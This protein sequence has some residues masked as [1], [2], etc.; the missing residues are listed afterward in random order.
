MLTQPEGPA[1]PYKNNLPSDL[2]SAILTEKVGLLQQG[3]SAQRPDPDSRWQLLENML[4]WQGG[5][6]W[7]TSAYVPKTEDS[8]P[9]N[10]TL[11]LEKD[12]EWIEALLT[13]V[14]GRQT[15]VKRILAWK[16]GRVLPS[17]EED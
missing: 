5:A 11:A 14:P 10:L 4:N 13:P 12:L 3:Y 6:S 7:D 1:L 2:Y 9:P 17:F 16:G 8:L 15:L